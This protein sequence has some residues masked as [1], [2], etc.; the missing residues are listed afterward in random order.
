[1]HKLDFKYRAGIVTMTG[2]A[3]LKNLPTKNPPAQPNGFRNFFSALAVF[4]LRPQ[5]VVQI[6]TATELYQNRPTETKADLRKKNAIQTR[7]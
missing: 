4:I 2:P 7:L 3:A 6:G 5:A 1:V